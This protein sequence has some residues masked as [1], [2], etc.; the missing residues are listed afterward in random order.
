MRGQCAHH[1]SG[2]PRGRHR[3]IRSGGVT[4]SAF[5]PSVVNLP[6]KVSL[7]SVAAHDYR[8]AIGSRGSGG[9]VRL[10]IRIWTMNQVRQA[11]MI[12]YFSFDT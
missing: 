9:P 11:L 1:G 8:R 12:T 5:S 3:N 4:R 6:I 7:R 10:H 2:S